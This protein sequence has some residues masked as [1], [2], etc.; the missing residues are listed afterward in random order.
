M[1]EIKVINDEAYCEECGKDVH[2]REMDGDV[3]KV[4]YPHV[5]LDNSG[6]LVAERETEDKPWQKPT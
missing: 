1:S 6:H 4:Q 5:L 3:T 2:V